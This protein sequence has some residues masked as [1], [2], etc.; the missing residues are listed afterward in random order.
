[1]A[2]PPHVWRWEHHGELASTQDRAIEAARAGEGGHL[3]ILADRQSAGRGSRGR[4]W[5]APAGNLNL[6]LLVRPGHVAPDPG[7]WSLLAALALHTALSPY[8]PGLMLKWPN[9]VLLNGGKL[10]GVLIDTQ[11]GAHNLPDWVVIGLGANLAAAPA[12]PGRA[13]AHLPLPAPA[14]GAIASAITHALDAHAHLPT[15]AIAAAWLARAHPIGTALD[16]RI[17]GSRFTGTFAG[18]SPAGALLLHNH[19]CPITS[20]EVFV[21]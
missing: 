5:S 11:M 6:S 20:A 19:P 7:R 15:D 14:P 16:I 9:D 3:A 8:A 10:A 21:S 18:L 17:P 2:G 4:V 1:M 12:I 13:T